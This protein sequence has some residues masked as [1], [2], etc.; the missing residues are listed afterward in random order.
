MSSYDHAAEISRSKNGENKRTRD[1][2]TKGT[3]NLNDIGV[4]MA[5]TFI[6]GVADSVWS[7]DLG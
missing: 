3:I 7:L 2:K 1:G 5:V 4:G 6:V